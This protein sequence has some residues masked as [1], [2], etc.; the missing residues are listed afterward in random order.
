MAAS[1]TFSNDF[2]EQFRQLLVWRRDVRRFQ[3][4]ALPAGLLEEL[5][6]LSS[7]SPSVG[8]C[9]PWRFIR[10]H[11]PEIRAAVRAEF[12]RA[13]AEALA[14]YLG[15]RAALYAGLKLA[16][17]D[18]APEQ[19]AVFAD[20]T[21]QKGSGLGRRTMPEMLEYSV[22]CAITTLWLA[23]RAYGVGM[24]WVSILDPA[25]VST[26]LSVPEDW[27]LIAYLCL[28]YSEE[29]SSTPELERAGWEIRARS[30][31]LLLE[32]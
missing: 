28:G 15:E 21:T 4:T 17:L 22:I 25:R 13:N 1:P 6:E 14:G 18:R 16:G 5:L 8:L 19:L 9:E 24:G 29:D 12:E 11:S 31:S 26:I 20:R 30:A 32:R 10:I 3:S 23:A 27:Q 2:R 7:L